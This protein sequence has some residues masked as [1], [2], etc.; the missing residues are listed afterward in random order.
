MSVL[1]TCMLIVGC[2]EKM[3]IILEKYLVEQRM[4]KVNSFGKMVKNILETGWTVR[5]MVK[6]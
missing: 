3:V 4:E 6:A 1:A 2:K 5:Q